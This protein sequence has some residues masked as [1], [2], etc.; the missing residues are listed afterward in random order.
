M[1][2]I[3]RSSLGLAL[4]FAFAGQA[5]AANFAT[6][7]LDKLPGVQN[8]VAAQAVFQ[9]C[10]VQHPGAF[11]MIKQGSGRSLFSYSTGADCTIK[12][13][14][15]TRSNRAA[16]LIRVA[17]R[18]LYDPPETDWERGIITPPG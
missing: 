6:C 15:E 16:G 13:A 3:T 18:R 5:Q 2:A 7:L 14:G 9:V 10:S 12:K 1:G 8:D 11:D 17:C 4:A